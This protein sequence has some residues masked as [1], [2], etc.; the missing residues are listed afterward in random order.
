MK[1]SIHKRILLSAV[2]ILI[3]FLGLTGIVLDRAFRNSVIAS[4]QENLRTQIYALL[5]TAEL[6]QNSRLMLPEEL[7]EPRLNMIDSS[8]YARVSRPDGSV[9][10]NSRSMIGSRIKLPA[11]NRLGE[12]EFSQAVTG[13]QV[14]T[15]ASFTAI[16]ISEEGEKKYTFHV[17]ENRQVLDREI[18]S[19]RKSLW[20]WL[21]GA[22]FLLLAVQGLIL[23]WGL[24]PLRNV[25]DDLHDIEKGRA[26]RL[27]GEYPAELS[28]LTDNLNSLLAS[29]RQ[30]LGRYR[31]ALGNM[32]HSLKTPIAVLGGILESVRHEQKDLA[33]EQL[34]TIGNIVE[35]Q[36]Q[37]ASAA[38][39]QGGSVFS[40]VKP[41][42]G[43]ILETLDKVYHSKHVSAEINMA[44]DCLIRMDRGDL[45]ELLGN[46]LDNAYKWC[47]DTVGITAMDEDGKTR[48]VV[49]DDGPGISREQTESIMQRGRRGDESIPGHGLGLAMVN[50]MVM[51]YN[52]ALEISDSELGGAKISVLIPD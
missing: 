8:L 41:V 36:L 46:L 51:L 40:D 19:F 47:H 29:S 14:Y 28:L 7:T 13:K 16:W 38:G 34:E 4:Q 3:L 27:A 45:F 32:A 37:R 24:A 17:A 10:W 25:A 20:G 48:I 33:A 22:A 31:D 39:Q 1:L 50:D 52:G 35:Y 26:D 12:F 44:D 9:L 30:Q 2:V 11:S 43:K 42:T 49:E 21:A 18:D 15:V 23:R 5:A 6:D